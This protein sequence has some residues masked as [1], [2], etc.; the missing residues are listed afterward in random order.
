MRLPVLAYGSSH[1]FY[2]FALKLTD[3]LFFDA[4]ARFFIQPSTF[5]LQLATINQ[6]DFT[7]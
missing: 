1:L 7:L 4:R 3:A 6:G 5:S 2:G